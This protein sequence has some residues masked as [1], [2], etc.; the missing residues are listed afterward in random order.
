MLLICELNK[1]CITCRD[2]MIHN[3]T[4]GITAARLFTTRNHKDTTMYHKDTTMYHKDTTRNL[5]VFLPQG[6]PGIPRQRVCLLVC[7]SHE[8]FFIYLATVTITGDRAANLDLCLALTAFISEC[9]LTCPTY[10][11][12]G[13]PFLRSYLKDP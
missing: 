12:T 7:L 5:C 6:H 4:I 10:C 3:F 1:Q 13:P 9:S 2:A 8:Q 11:D